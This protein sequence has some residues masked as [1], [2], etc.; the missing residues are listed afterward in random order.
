MKVKIGPYKNWIGPYQLADMVFFWLPQHVSEEDY[1]SRWDFRLHDRF[2]KWLASTWVAD[3][4]Q[5]ID[6]KRQRDVKIHIDRYDTWNMDHTLALIIVPMLKQLKESGHGVP[7]I[8]DE[9]VPEELRST[10]AS[11]KENEWDVDDN[12]EKRWEWVID[13]MIWAFTEIMEEKEGLDCW[14]PYEEGEEVRTMF[15]ETIDE[16]RER[17]KYDREKS[18]AYNERLRKA[19]TLF[20]KY[21]Q[22]L[23]D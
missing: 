6:S 18:V 11:P 7:Y 3:L 4:C 23:W 8:D 5:W 19:T 1:E 16:A 15:G 10:A 9:D 12:H 14:V 20:G 22:A 17:G 21:Y 13:E 2:G